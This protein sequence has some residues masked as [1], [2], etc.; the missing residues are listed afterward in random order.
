MLLTHDLICVYVR[1]GAAGLYS[2]EPVRKKWSLASGALKDASQ[3]KR[4][5]AS[6]DAF[7]G[8]SVSSTLRAGQV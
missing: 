4:K 6:V 1:T 8:M 5:N 3:N 7:Q 2:T